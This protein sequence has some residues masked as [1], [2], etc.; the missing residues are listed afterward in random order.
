MDEKLKCPHKRIDHNGEC[1]D[2]DEP[3]WADQTMTPID[4]A[5]AQNEARKMGKTYLSGLDEQ[6]QFYF[7]T[8]YLMA[9]LKYKEIKHEH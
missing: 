7:A 5:A 8:G 9:T 3:V 1:L 4:K 2:C 6:S